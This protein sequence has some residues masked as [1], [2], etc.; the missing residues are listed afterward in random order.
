MLNVG[1][2]APDFSLTADDGSFNS[3]IMTVGDE[4]STT[5]GTAGTF[6]YFCA[7]HPEMTGTVT[8]SE[9]AP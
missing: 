3:G 4:F 6:D 9:A 8:V 2:I 7:I 1:D 5:F